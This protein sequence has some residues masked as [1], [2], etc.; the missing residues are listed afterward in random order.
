MKSLF[1]ILALSLPAS[2]AWG[3]GEDK[4]GP[5]GG[6][7]QMPG[8]FHT[9]LVPVGKNKLKV[10]LLDFNWKNPSVKDSSL[11]V[12]YHSGDPSS[13]K[14]EAACEIKE[15]RYYLCSFPK[16]L[17]VTKSGKLTL[18][19]KREGQEGM[20]ISYDLPLKLAAPADSH[21]GHHHH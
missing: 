16:T 3:H 17:D 21:K 6:F 12:T 8:A 13:K 2:L 18:A 1:L 19:S 10:F 5:N 11:K 15:S 14:P 4:S 9:E 20:E 7:I